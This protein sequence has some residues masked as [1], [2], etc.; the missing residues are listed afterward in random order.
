[1]KRFSALFLSFALI[2][3]VAG[4]GENS[5]IVSQGGTT[6]LMEGINA[7]VVAV[8]PDAAGTAAVTDFGVRLVQNSLDHGENLLISPLSVLS[9]LAMTANGAKDATRAQMEEVFG[10]SID[11]LNVYLRW[12]VDSL[13]QG[14]NYSLRLA[15]SIW[16]TE[17]TRFTP[18]P[19]FLQINADYYGADIYTAPF[20]ESTKDA[21]NRWVEEKTD[22]MIDQILD[23]IPDE[24]LMYLINALAFEAQWSD[25]YEEHQV[26][27]GVFT[28]EDGSEQP[29]EMM[30]AQEYRYLSDE[31]TTG[32]IKNYEDRSYAFVALL[33]REGISMEDYIA[34]LTG[35]RIQSLLNNMHETPV[36]TSMPK[37]E[38]EY[39][40]ELSDILVKMGMTDAFDWT[41]A[42]FSALGTSEDGNIHME[43]VLHKTFISVTEQGTRAGAA[44]VV[45]MT[46]GAAMPPDKIQEVYLDRPFVYLLIDCENG[47]P[48]FI[49]VLMDT[50]N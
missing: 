35:D 15:N 24:A 48:F 38:T 31:L 26:R 6:N 11:E 50:E 16:L 2:L 45:E 37:F 1:M 5:S 41:K 40:V 20:D 22:E 19:E 30:Y 46:D 49:G 8:Q 42:D 7:S 10:M 43:R 14:K 17:D 47:L 33:P 9:A 4:C 25:M 23:K 29:V 36:Q 3:S 44:T 28:R 27:D 18:E 39:S 12:Y 21:I 32:F 34:A 13:P